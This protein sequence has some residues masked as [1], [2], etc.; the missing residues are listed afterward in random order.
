MYNLNM[1]SPQRNS[2]LYLSHVHF[3]YV[4]YN[5]LFSQKSNNHIDIQKLQLD[6]SERTDYW[7]CSAWGPSSYHPRHISSG[8][9]P[10]TVSPDR[11]PY[12]YGSGGQGCRRIE[13]DILRTITIKL[14][15]E[16]VIERQ[17][18]RHKVRQTYRQN[19]ERE[20]D[21]ERSSIFVLI[22]SNVHISRPTLITY[23]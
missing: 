1:P 11:M 18:D 16:R 3:T 2:N 21:W 6:W 23:P 12:L 5:F 22:K 19:D 9:H 14:H 20:S 17:T 15:T 13:L 7:C 10:A 4:G 8:T